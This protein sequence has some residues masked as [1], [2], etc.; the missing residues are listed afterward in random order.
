MCTFDFTCFGV[1]FFSDKDDSFRIIRC[2][3]KF[4]KDNCFRTKAKKIGNKAYFPVVITGLLKIITFVKLTGHNKDRKCMK[5]AEHWKT[6]TELFL[7]R[8]F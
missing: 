5:D 7:T 3:T 2:L 6:F 8:I 1:L 4:V